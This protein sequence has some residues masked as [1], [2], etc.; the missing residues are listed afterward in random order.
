MYSTQTCSFKNIWRGHL[1]KQLW[2]PDRCKRKEGQLSTTLAAKGC[3]LSTQQVRSFKW[4]D[5][6][7]WW[8]REERLTSRESLCLL[9]IGTWGGKSGLTNDEEQWVQSVL[10][11]RHW[12]SFQ[13]SE[14]F[15]HSIIL[16]PKKPLSSWNLVNPF[17]SMNEAWILNKNTEQTLIPTLNFKT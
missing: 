16:R 13:L 14:E 2:P 11:E 3:N 7:K 9:A 1:V 4:I 5:P 15:H 6:S 17:L 12:A 8:W 10:S